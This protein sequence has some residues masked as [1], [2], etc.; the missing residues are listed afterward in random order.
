MVPSAARY[1][2][3]R[4]DAALSYARVQH[5]R[6]RTSVNDVI[7]AVDIEVSPVISFVPSM[8]RKA[9]ATPTSSIETRLRVGAFD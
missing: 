1:T 8:P 5:R 7:A 6:V 2:F 4:N 3:T 9:T